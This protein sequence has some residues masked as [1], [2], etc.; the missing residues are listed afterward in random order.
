MELMENL[1]N[2]LGGQLEQ[3]FEHLA[4]FGLTLV[5]GWVE[6]G[7]LASVLARLFAALVT[8]IVSGMF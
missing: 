4:D 3:F 8:G 7:L 5:G 2:C 6:L 1:I